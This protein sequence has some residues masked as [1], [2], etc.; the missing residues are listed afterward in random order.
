MSKSD[1]ALK[2]VKTMSAFC[3]HRY[4]S[5][6]VGLTVNSLAHYYFHIHNTNTNTIGPIHFYSLHNPVAYTVG[7]V[8]IGLA[9]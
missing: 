2:R 7:Y 5:R 4:S 3:L 6:Q 9:L 1:A 8:V